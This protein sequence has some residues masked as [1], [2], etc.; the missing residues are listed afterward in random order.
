MHNTKK[1]QIVNGTYYDARTSPDVVRALE[2]ARARGTRVRLYL[3]D[4]A[5]GRDWDERYDVA[6]RIG[7]SMGPEKIPI[8]VHN[9]R[10]MGGGGILDHCIVRIAESNGGRVLYQ[11]SN[12]HKVVELSTNE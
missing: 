2:S 12:Y 6:G 8:L 7:R 9:S 11:A 3:G 1:Y 5:T 10:S 4:A